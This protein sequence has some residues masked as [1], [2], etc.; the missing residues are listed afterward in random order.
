MAIAYQR[1]C[2]TPFMQNCRIF[3]DDESLEC[4]VVDAGGS[5]VQI[6]DFIKQNGLKLKTILITHM[7][8]DHVGG[9]YELAELTGAKIMGPTIEDDPLLHCLNMQSDAFGLPKSEQ[10]QTQ[11]LNDGDIII[12]IEGFSLKV[13]HTPGHTPGGV[14]YYSDA[15]KFVL[16]GDT[17]FA[18]S[19]GRTDFPLGSYDAIISSIKEKLYT[20]DK[21]T[22][23][24]PGHGEDSVI[25]NEIRENPYTV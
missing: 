13:I 23:V 17:L 5:A 9:V 1:I 14:C 25:E 21:S 12:P 16:T 15:G 24:L 11:Y 20:L 3:V 6:A 2:V 18:G 4:F 19:I 7:H 22:A 8:L 10:F